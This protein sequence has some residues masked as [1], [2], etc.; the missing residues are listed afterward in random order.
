MGTELFLLPTKDTAL[1][2]IPIVA[3]PLP[4]CP[5]PREKTSTIID[6][7]TYPLVIALWHCARNAIIIILL[8][9]TVP[10]MSSSLS[11]YL[12]AKWFTSA[13]QRCDI[14]TCT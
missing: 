14:V 11:Y 6:N 3:M 1:T 12:N 5:S 10:A 8:Y 9:G 13:I 2:N 7:F 4:G